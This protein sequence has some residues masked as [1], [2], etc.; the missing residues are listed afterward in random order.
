MLKWGTNILFGA[1]LGRPYSAPPYGGL[2]LYS[3]YHSPVM[4]GR[5]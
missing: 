5:A 4:K 2:A 3:V 1:E